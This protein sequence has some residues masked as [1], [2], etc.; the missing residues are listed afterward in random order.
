MRRKLYCLAIISILLLGSVTL[1]SGKKSKNPEEFREL[2]KVNI[3]ISSIISDLGYTEEN[4]TDVPDEL[5]TKIIKSRHVY[6]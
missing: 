1:A 2:P 4:I 6:P 5:I 3:D